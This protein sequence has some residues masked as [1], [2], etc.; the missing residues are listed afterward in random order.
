[1][2]ALVGGFGNMFFGDDGFGCEVARRL[3]A[4]ELP[5]NVRVV[6]FGIRGMHAAFEML[7]GYDVAIL[8]DAVSRGDAPGTLYVIEPDDVNDAVP[9]AHAMELHA[10][11]AMF[12]RLAA[13]LSPSIRPATTIVGCE[14]ENLSERIALSPAVASSVEPAME[15]VRRL[16]AQHG[17]GVQNYEAR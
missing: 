14:P 8:I 17:I 5:E 15:L 12:D 16:L 13:S 7:D 11:L 3:A 4:G 9:D 6:D 1:M 10:L 2:K